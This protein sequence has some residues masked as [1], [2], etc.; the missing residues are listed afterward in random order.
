MI[1]IFV[2]DFCEI[3][4]DKVKSTLIQKWLKVSRRMS[5]IEFSEQLDT[6]F[7]SIEVFEPEV[8]MIDAHNFNYRIG[9]KTRFSISQFLNIYSIKSLIL[10]PSKGFAGLR[11]FAVLKE[12][13]GKIINIR[14]LN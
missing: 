6:L 13:T 1:R 2:N 5:D 9:G 12:L 14:I 4:F 8:L 7:S 10:I 3:V 11:S